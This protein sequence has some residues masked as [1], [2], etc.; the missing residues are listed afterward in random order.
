MDISY[1]S[2][3]LLAL[4]KDSL[5]LSSEVSNILQH[6]SSSQ[7][8][9][10]VSKLALEPQWTSAV[11]T[12]HR[13]LFVDIC[14]R[15]ISRKDFEARVVDVASAL[16]KILPCAPHLSEYAE[17]LVCQ[18]QAGAIGALSSP[19]IDQLNDIPEKILQVLLLTLVR[20]LIFDNGT[21]A[22]AISPA[23]MQLLLVH[24][25]LSVRYLAIK[26]IALYLHASDETMAEMVK[27]YI[28]DIEVFGGYEN[29]TIDFTFFGLWEEKRISELQ[30]M[31]RHHQQARETTSMRTSAQRIV[32][33]TDLSDLTASFAGTLVPRIDGK[34]EKLSN[35]VMNDSTLQNLKL[36]AEAINK[37]S[38]ILIT[39][40]S[41]SGKTL[42]IN[43]IAQDLAKDSKLLTLHLNEQTDA[44]LLIGMYKSVKTPGE[45]TWQPGVLTTAVLQGR[46][47]LIED[48]DRAPAEVVS[49]LLPLL[50]RGELL[51]P[52][53]GD[54]VRASPGFKLIATIRSVL[55]IQGKEI[56]PGPAI[57]GARYW[58]QVSL[59]MPS[60]TD[61]GMV[62]SREFNLL[63]GYS[64]DI[65][66][67]Y[68]ELSSDASTVRQYGKKLSTGRP[69]GPRDLMKLCKRLNMLLM[70]SGAQCGDEPF[71]EGFQDDMFLE[72]VDCF[73]AGSQSKELKD[74]IIASIAH[75]LRIPTARSDYCMSVR[76][77][78]CSSVPNGLSIGRVTLGR[79]SSTLAGSRAAQKNAKRPFAMTP[80]A[81]RLCESIA[82]A[83]KMQEPCLLVGE[84]GTGK[85]A[86]I[87]EL[88]ERLGHHLVV[89]NL[90]QQSEAGDLL[91]GYKPLSTRSL[92]LPMKE[93]FER[94]FEMTFSQKRNHRYVE[95]LGRTIA[96]G[97]WSRTLILW[98]EALRMV[99]DTFQSVS[100]DHHDGDALR[101][102]K[103]RKL[104]SPRHQK[105]M[106]RWGLF[107]S[108]VQVFEVHLQKGD[109]GVAFSFVEGNI[110]KAARNGDWVLLDEI[111]L[112][113]PDTLEG[114][115][116]LLSGGAGSVPSVLLPETGSLDRIYAHESF[117]IFGAMNPATD[118]GKRDLPIGLR[119]RFTE[120]FVEEP[121]KDLGSL[122][123]VV[124][125]Y[126][127][128]H[129]HTD[130]RAASDVA[131]LYLEIKKLIRENCLVDGANHKP[132]VS[133][134]SLTRTLVFATDTAPVYGLRRSLYEG[135]SMSFLTLLNKESESR[136]LP[137][138]S[139]YILGSR[140]NR[141]ALLKQVTRPPDTTRKYTRFMQYW[142]AQGPLPI[143]ERSRYII[144]PFVE[145][146][147]LNLV[148]ATSTRRFPVL[149]QGPTSS[150]KTSMIEHLAQI[151]GNKFVR[152][153]NHEHTDLQE[154]LG[155]YVS[156]SAG[157]LSF[158]EGI[159]VNALREGAWIV[160]DELNLAPTDVLEA[161]N[162]LLD[163]NRELLI[164][165]TQEI[166][167]PHENF[168]LFAT[169][170]PPGL[171][172]GRKVLSR[173]FRNRFLE[174]HFDDIPEDE[175][176]TILR[177]RS[178]IAPSFCS[179]IVAV[180]KRLSL[181]R[182][183][184]RIFEQGNSFATLRDLFRWA[185]RDADDREQLA[186]NGYMLLA[187]RV[188]NPEER[189]VVKA[190]IEEIMKVEIKESN[191]YS[192]EHV[193]SLRG[194][195]TDMLASKIVWTKSMRRLF[196]LISESLK[197]NEPVLLVGET[198]SGKT[199]V[200][201]V[202]AEVMGRQ[203]KIVNAHQNTETGDLIGAHRPLRN[204]AAIQKQLVQDISKVLQSVRPMNQLNSSLTSMLEMYDCLLVEGFPQGT[205]DVLERIA[206]ARGELASIF[207][208]SDG[209]LVQAMKTGH[210]F[211]LDEISL[212]DDSVLERLNSVLE[213]ARELLLA[214][215][216][217]TD[218]LVHAENG[219]QFLATMNPG[220]DYGKKELSP[221]LRN[222]FTEIWV[223][224]VSDSQDI[225]EIATAKLSPSMSHF[226]SPLVDFACWFGTEHAKSPSISIR[227]VLAWIQILNIHNHLNPYHS[228]LHG[229]AM[230]YIDGI[231]AN[232]AATLH[233][234]EN[235]IG[236]KRET[237]LERLSEFF[238]HDMI[239][240]YN[241]E[242][243]ITNQERYLSIGHFRLRKHHVAISPVPFSLQAPTTKAN[244]MRIIRALQVQ[245]PILLEGSPGVGKTSLVTALAQAVGMPLTRINLSEQTDIMDLFGSDVP[246]E[247]EGVASF[248]WR[249]APFL[250]AMQRGEWVL[251]D[252]M[253]LASQSVLEGLNACLDHRGEVFVPGLDQS[254]SR[255]PG[256]AVFAA[257]NPH[258][259]GG[260]RKGLPASF[261]N[262]F[263][264][265]YADILGPTD[266]LLIG[267]RLYPHV[268]AGIIQEMIHYVS[269]LQR[270][271]QLNKGVASY[272]GPWEF[273]LRD[274]LRWL[275]LLTSPKSLIPAVSASDFCDVLFF[276]RLRLSTPDVAPIRD[277]MP[278]ALTNDRFSGVFENLSTG[279]YQVGLA[280]L[281]RKQ[282]LQ[283][284]LSRQQVI[285]Q[286]TKFPKLQSIMFCIQ[287]NWP[288]LLVGSTG[289]G[290]TSAI[291][292]L[293]VTL[294][295]DLVTMPLNADMDTMDLIGRYEQASL[296]RN[297][298]K[299][300]GNVRRLLRRLLL[301]Q[302]TAT[303]HRD[304]IKILSQMIS[305]IENVDL[306]SMQ[307][308]LSSLFTSTGLSDFSVLAQEGQTLLK[309][310]ALDH[311]AQ[312][313]WVDGILIEAL[314][315]GQWLVLD[316]A[317]LCSS[318]V[319]DRLT[320]LLEPDGHLSVTE[321]RCADGTA[322]LVKPH[323]KFRLF[324]TMDPVHGELSQ[325]MRNRCI[326][327]YMPVEIKKVET[328]SRRSAYEFSMFRYQTFQLFDWAL[329][330]NAV[331]H[332]L[333]SLCLDHLAFR[334][335]RLLRRWLQQAKQGLV[336][337]PESVAKS[338]LP[339]FESFQK[340]MSSR[341]SIFDT[342]WKYYTHLDMKF[343]IDFLEAQVSHNSHCLLPS[344]LIMQSIDD[345]SSQQYCSFIYS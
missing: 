19:D 54:P 176:E 298:A 340:L 226:A 157:Q 246:I 172:G 333:V 64:S 163:D 4:T 205:P 232:P 332:D 208:W 29:Q 190:V 104:E 68:S 214:E 228:I 13:S 329:F 50:E 42:M 273:N 341:G 313:E 218:A 140:S 125:A 293:A 62:I 114:I 87:Q 175:L 28:G 237:C 57:L 316:N 79:H 169:Q 181:L 286:A 248:T 118:V 203:L 320:A 138:I 342:I 92:A 289:S 254:F 173:A 168:M 281:D 195:D 322:R 27:I 245:K 108:Q 132:H 82:V 317:N 204:R 73:A 60:E 26:I 107:A 288:C 90:S 202:I 193:E 71:T 223:P 75:T 290:K 310:L 306:Q 243:I 250:R 152:I 231:G 113:S 326:E 241:E 239:A 86:S 285:H 216:G 260:G 112:A 47:I 284:S 192:A 136:A 37:S 291:H 178:Q 171:Y 179:K 67:L 294:G 98:Q 158:R 22:S 287:H 343:P 309:R 252:E 234:A 11:F 53:L 59:C 184:S 127:G 278:R 88:A 230:V 209:S 212:A 58:N 147:L 221:A 137:L 187:E 253:N 272:G 8:L 63:K 229:A 69:H 61:L 99:R 274:I 191:I 196:I 233:V 151:S 131:K 122:I 336:I 93:E 74:E 183:T 300:R 256:F 139:D 56:L 303:G 222:R 85:T 121:D 164:P 80:H 213:P 283:R 304:F 48:L 1:D 95:Q 277:R 149:L 39:G 102:A 123:K 23:K 308:E 219:F 78:A 242:I 109:K 32:D 120:Y 46:W 89:V 211:L 30:N 72:A 49:T 106:S 24:S 210:H 201:Q 207:E 21:F 134:R 162:R 144:T 323:P 135:F 117:R 188:R 65:M 165:E 34:P 2:A 174:L 124:E 116:D 170:N 159:L 43:S 198:G 259:H 296:E 17:L 166:V 312:F 266:L 337:L 220:G 249:D 146:N 331:S 148:R 339:V 225:L 189:A 338:I 311:R 262:R 200:C 247:N 185:F 130:V 5:H 235:L 269:N 244:A 160:L 110:V 55:N 83:V 155:T 215:K 199:S 15:W 129:T 321:Q 40:R 119:S 280:V 302:L 167:R 177:E 10:A 97:N 197:N 261:V 77:P 142:V 103:R 33:P 335:L 186:I 180:Y 45:F 25:N 255:H 128:A 6:G 76:I 270:Y 279:S 292:H 35:L 91:G 182:Q 7:Y 84:T 96:K 9:D 334:D 38:P 227:E 217:P 275:E 224:P 153:N 314:E 327:L 319:L 307:S 14:S 236:A 133:L 264:L 100:Q 276:Q 41:G 258:H 161:L 297:E 145:R 66:T 154:Y 36:V 18:R 271:L 251:L 115:A 31:S 150:G 318:S 156:D 126:L 328:K 240:L 194:P 282:D 344:V 16:A 305:N 345:T 105:L 206:I 315:N 3:S 263:T 44:K 330:H 238:R 70:V 295:A 51:V 111:N 20:L 301:S 101:N 299:L 325:A 52:N 267:Q 81:V 324:L 94:L 143:A 257:Q 268:S 265:V 12:T 141:R